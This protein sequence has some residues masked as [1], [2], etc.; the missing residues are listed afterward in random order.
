MEDKGLREDKGK[1]ETQ[2]DEEIKEEDA[3][4]SPTDTVTVFLPTDGPSDAG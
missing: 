4:N 1:N 2:N 3:K